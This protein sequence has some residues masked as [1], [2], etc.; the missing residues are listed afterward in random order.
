MDTSLLKAYALA[1]YSVAEEMNEIEEVKEGLGFVCQV[2]D[3]NNELMKFLDSPK[4]MNAEK[5]KTLSDVFGKNIPGCLLSFL[6]VLVKRRKLKGIHEIEKQYI[7]CYNRKHGILEGRI[8]TP[9]E[10]SKKRVED[11][12][13]MFSEKY[14]QNVKFTISIDKRVVAGMRIYVDDT[15]YD[16]SIDTKLD[17]I[18]DSLMIDTK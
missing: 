6:N 4:I 10:L 1:M 3:A 18:R 5:E 17:R 14:D 15:L 8:Y 2:I 12:E 13:K 16:Y 11:L 7:H 9:F